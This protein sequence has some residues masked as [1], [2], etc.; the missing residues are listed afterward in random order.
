[1]PRVFSSKINKPLR[2]FLNK[3]KV[4]NEGEEK[5]LNFLTSVLKGLVGNG[6]NTSMSTFE[7]VKLYDQPYHKGTGI[8]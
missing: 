4:S 8:K 3:L 1:M 6:L 2:P 5:V 7:L